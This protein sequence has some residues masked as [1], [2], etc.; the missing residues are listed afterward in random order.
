VLFTIETLEGS[1]STPST[2][3]V[4]AVGGAV[5][6][7]KSSLNVNV[8]VVP[9]EEITGAGVAKTGPAVS[10]IELFA[11]TIESLNGAASYPSSPCT[12][13]FAEV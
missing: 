1:I 4:N 9:D 2:N 5:V 10:T 12:A 7:L 6:E 13:E 3:T 8:N 11:V